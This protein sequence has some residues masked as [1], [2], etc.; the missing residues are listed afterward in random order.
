MEELEQ[1]QEKEARKKPGQ[2]KNKLIYILFLIVIIEGLAFW[3]YCQSVGKKVQKADGM[4]EQIE[5][6]NQEKQRCSDILTQASGEFADYEYCK[7][8]LQRFSE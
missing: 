4:I 7:K 1:E 3:F 8:L 6:L 2:W 5:T